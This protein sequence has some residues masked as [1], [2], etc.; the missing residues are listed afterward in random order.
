MGVDR[1]RRELQSGV[2]GGQRFQYLIP[3]EIKAGAP[4]VVAGL[5]G[6]VRFVADRL[7]QVAQR[8]DLLILSQVFAGG[9]KQG[10]RPE[11]PGQNDQFRS[12]CDCLGQGGTGVGLP[13]AALEDLSFGAIG[14]V[15]VRLQP[16]CRI[17]DR[18]APLSSR[19]ERSRSKPRLASKAY[20]NRRWGSGPGRGSSLPQAA[21]K[22]SAASCG[23]GD[24]CGSAVC[25]GEICPRARLPSSV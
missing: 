20:R 9:V 3:A 24:A 15:L 10:P 17:R 23:I 12:T 2:A 16:D 18:R 21:S 25:S 8:R 5:G 11:E 13:A 14:L 22:A 6:Q 4:N 7:V 19:P 1:A